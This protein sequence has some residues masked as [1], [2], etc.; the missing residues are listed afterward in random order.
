MKSIVLLVLA[1]PV[2]FQQAA[3]LE[4]PALQEMVQAEREFAAMGAE[5]G[6]Y[7]S[8]FKYFGEEGI[9]FNPHP[10]KFREGA[11]ANPPPDPPPP[12]QFKLEWWPVYG[13]V[14]ESGDLGYNTGPTL[15]TDLTPQ[16][17]PARHGY[18]FSVWKKQADGAWNVAV[19]MG[20]GTPDAD[21]AWQDRL[22]YVRAPQDESKVIAT[23]DASSGREEMMKLEGEFSKS[24]RESTPSGYAKYTARIVR[25]HRPGAFPI[26]GREA[27]TKFVETSTLAV[28]EWEGI[29]GGVARSGELGYTYGRYGIRVSGTSE[30]GYFTHVWKRDGKGEWKLVAEV[31]SPMPSEAR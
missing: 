15:V 8:F 27:V 1:V 3:R 12:R 7:E 5:K 9:G 16:N 30:K 11:R 4:P 10:G 2:A 22:R 6:V 18:F 24:T 23:R 20:V 21:P 26:L 19:D 17:R 31:M 14:S 29:D 13:D 25:L 28:D